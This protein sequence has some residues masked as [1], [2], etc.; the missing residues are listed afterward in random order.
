MAPEQS[1]Q[2]SDAL[3]GDVT[4]FSAF[5]EKSGLPCLVIEQTED[6]AELRF[7]GPF[8]GRDVVWCCEFM[9]LVAE[10][11]RLAQEI[12][13]APESLRNFIEI[14]DPESGGVPIR[15]GLA[16]PRIDSA[17]ID[18]MILMIRLYKNL[19]RGRHEYGEAVN[20]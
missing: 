17:A 12:S 2:N 8:E 6:R 20:P 5:L 9:T 7:V 16:L 10:L 1:N 14:G 4:C 11:N 13:P 19:R 3:S 18:K 15:V